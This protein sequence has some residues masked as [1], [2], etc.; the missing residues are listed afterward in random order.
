MRSDHGEHTEQRKRSYDGKESS[1]E[2]NFVVD[3]GDGRTIGIEGLC[4][5][6][7]LRVH[8]AW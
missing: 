8:A 7:P 1:A 3:R 6:R 5:R 2:A 4:H